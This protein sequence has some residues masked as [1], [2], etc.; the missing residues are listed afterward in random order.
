MGMTDTV[1]KEYMR[2]NKVFAD[3]FNYLI[4]GGEQVVKPALLQELDTTEIAIPFALDEEE[5][6]TEEAVQK[7][8][9]VLKSTVIM[10]DAKASYILLGVENQTDIHYAMPVR[11][12]IYDALQYG[13][14]VS[15]VAK[16]HKNQSDGK[17]HNRGEYLSGFYKEDRIRPVITLVIH[18]GADEWDG[19]LSL[20]EMM[21]LEDEKLLE[22]VQDYRIFLIDPYKL[23]HD[24]LEKFSSSLGDVLG[25]IKYSK[26]KN[27]LS[28]FLND[29]QVMIIDNDAARVIRDI[30]NTP[31]YVPDGKGEIDMCKAVKDMIYEER[32]LT[33]IELVRD[34]S[35]SI[36]KASAKANMTVEQFKKVM[37]DTNIK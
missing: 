27:A 5:S 32:I 16:K 11:N 26:D 35:L 14:Q 19:P 3:A 24:D 31:I 18:F 12:I 25:Y 33:L 30:T 23:T 1:T 36:E 2:G 8:R 28:K 10:Q 20:Y 13:K 7:Y 6:T 29:S 21:D 22:F 15:E 4:Y 17:R 9:D 34:N 37:E